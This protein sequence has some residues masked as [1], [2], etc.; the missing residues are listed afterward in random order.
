MKALIYRIA[1]QNAMHP[2]KTKN[3]NKSKTKLMS[4][5]FLCLSWGPS[6]C[7]GTP[8]RAE[9]WIKLVDRYVCSVEVTCLAG[10]RTVILAVAQAPRAALTPE[11]A[12]V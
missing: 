6:S 7:L 9:M 12:T 3:K 8:C 10:H 2:K 1:D 11:A 5:R 4:V